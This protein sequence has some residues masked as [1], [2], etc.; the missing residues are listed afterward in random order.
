MEEKLRM[1]KWTVCLPLGDFPSG[2]LDL[3]TGWWLL[4][5]CLKR[6]PVDIA[7]TGGTPEVNAQLASAICGPGEEIEEEEWETDDEGDEE[8]ETDEEGESEDSEEDGVQ[9]R[10]TV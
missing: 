3:K 10:N 6:F 1:K 8:E 2:H 7:V 9:M 4:Y 5:N